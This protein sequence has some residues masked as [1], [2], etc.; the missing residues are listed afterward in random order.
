MPGF[1]FDG[2]RHRLSSGAV[3]VPRPAMMN[4]FVLVVGM[5]CAELASMA[6][7]PQLQDQHQ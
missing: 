1:N 3:E 5:L 7:R 6:S 2:G 4:D